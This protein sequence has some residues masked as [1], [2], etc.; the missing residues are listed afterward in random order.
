MISP[1]SVQTDNEV[2]DSHGN[3]NFLS[4]NNTIS[5]DQNVYD[6][7]NQL[8][9]G[10]GLSHELPIVQQ[11]HD[12]PVYG[13][14]SPTMFASERPC[15]KEVYDAFVENPLYTSGYETRELH[16]PGDHHLPTTENS[17]HN[18]TAS[19]AEFQIEL[20]NPLY[21]DV[22]K[23]DCVY[24]EGSQSYENVSPTAM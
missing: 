23:N 7:P 4:S 22:G 14:T 11:Q 21:G 19:A 17:L 2:G 18:G 15:S 24:L 9:S 3:T 8:L 5:K 6:I 13:L 10:S 12:N 1:S 16:Q 20:N